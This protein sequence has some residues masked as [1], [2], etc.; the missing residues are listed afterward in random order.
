MDTW[1]FDSECWIISTQYTF[2]HIVITVRGTHGSTCNQHVALGGPV[3]SCDTLTMLEWKC[4]DIT[5][6]YK[7]NKKHLAWVH[8]P[9]SVCAPPPTW[10]PSWH[11]C[12]LHCCW[13]T[14]QI[15]KFQGGGVIYMIWLLQLNLL[16]LS[17]FQQ[18]QDTGTVTSSWT[19]VIFSTYFALKLEFPDDCFV[20]R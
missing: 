20:A 4:S 2:I 9:L 5:V 1:N 3:H 7:W 18:W 16:V 13:G 19:S 14:W 15:L 10:C 8:L 6:E 11:R 12:E 17:P